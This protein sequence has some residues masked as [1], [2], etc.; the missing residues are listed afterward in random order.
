M[1]KFL[2]IAADFLFIYLFSVQ[3]WLKAYKYLQMIFWNAFGENE[4]EEYQG[5]W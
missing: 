3:I 5:C 1:V 2:H 4:W